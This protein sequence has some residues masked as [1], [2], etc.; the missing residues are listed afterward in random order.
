MVPLAGVERRR[1]PR[2]SMPMLNELL[3]DF[4]E[5]RYRFLFAVVASAGVLT[6]FNEV[7]GTQLMGHPMEPP[8]LVDRIVSRIRH[9][10]W[11]EDIPTLL[12]I[13]VHFFLIFLIYPLGYLTYPYRHFPGPAIVRGL[14]YGL[15]LATFLAV[16]VYPIASFPMPFVDST[17][18]KA[19]ALYLAQLAYGI[20]LALILGLPGNRGRTAPTA[21]S[22]LKA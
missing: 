21:R 19:K 2:R 8:V 20:T 18:N 6:F 7:V 12:G 17:P 5:H 9:T 1:G 3:A 13:A 4:R 10:P 11:A 15:I 22:S 14:L 16:V